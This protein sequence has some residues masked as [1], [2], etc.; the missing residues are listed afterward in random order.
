MPGSQTQGAELFGTR[1]TTYSYPLKCFKKIYI[2]N[3]GVAT[4]PAPTCNNIG[5]IFRTGEP[6][7]AR[8][9]YTGSR[10]LWHT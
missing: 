7:D 4:V 6:G 1:R 10:T 8:W 9:P 2:S 3:R 5:A